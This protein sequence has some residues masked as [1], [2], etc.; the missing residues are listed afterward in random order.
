MDPN[1]IAGMA[2]TLI[3]AAMVGGFVLLFPV[4]RRLGKFLENKLEDKKGTPALPPAEFKAL[5]ETVKSLESQ[6][7]RVGERQEFLEKLLSSKQ[8]AALPPKDA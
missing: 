8:S 7:H 1:A 4:S 5:Q 2:F 6:L 3:L